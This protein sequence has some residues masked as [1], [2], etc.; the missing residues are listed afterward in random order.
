MTTAAVKGLRNTFAV[1]CK[2][3]HDASLRILSSLDPLVQKYA[4][5]GTGAAAA[6]SHILL[7]SQQLRQ[8]GAV[9]VS[10]Y[11]CHD[12]SPIGSG[13]EH[14]RIQELEPPHQCMSARQL[15]ATTVLK[16]TTH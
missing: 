7:R 9:W 8:G 4:R 13:T 3:S 16:H 15:T 10:L 11:W 5:T 2:R 6:V 14:Q 12:L 1:T